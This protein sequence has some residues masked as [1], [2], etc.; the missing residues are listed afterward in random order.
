MQFFD[1]GSNEDVD[2][3]EVE[4]VFQL[5]R[6]TPAKQIVLQYTQTT[7]AFQKD[8]KSDHSYIILDGQLVIVF[9]LQTSEL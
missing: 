5:L 2:N 6:L 9:P 4:P 8:N 3:F 1:A 7:Q